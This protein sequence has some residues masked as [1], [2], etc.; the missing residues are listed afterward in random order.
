MAHDFVHVADFYWLMAQEFSVFTL[1]RK[2]GQWQLK[3]GHYIGV[4]L[5]PS[6]MTLEILPKLLAKNESTRSQRQ[7][8][9]YTCLLYTSPSPRD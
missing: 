9:R 3:V 1:K 6:S 5:L 2:Q 4:I 7:P 8:P